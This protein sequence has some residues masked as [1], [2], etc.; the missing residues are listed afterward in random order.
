M[1]LPVRPLSLI[2]ACFLMMVYPSLVWA[3][4]HEPI[5]IHEAR[6]RMGDATGAERPHFDDADWPER[7]LY[8][9][10]D[11]RGIYWIRT[12]IR[13]S[14]DAVHHRPAGVLLSALASAEMFWDG[15][16]IGRKGQVGAAAEDEQPGPLRS[17][18]HIPDSLYTPGEHVLAI[19]LSNHHMPLDFEYSLYGLIVGPL[20]AFERT[21]ID[22][23][24]LLFVGGFLFIVVY[25]GLLFVLDPTRRSL[26]ILALFC[27][28]ISFVIGT[29]SL[30]V[31]YNYTYDWHA[32]RIHAITGLTAAMG[33]L[34]VA[35][36][37]IH[38][39]VPGKKRWLAIVAAITVATITLVA[40]S[41]GAVY[42]MYFVMT[43]AAL[44]ATI[45]AVHAGR[46][47]AKLACGGLALCLV[48]LLSTGTGFSS[49]YFS[50]AFSVF[51][52]GLLGTLAARHHREETRRRKAELRQ[53]QLETELLKRHIQPH[54]LMNTLTAAMEWIEAQPDKGV[55]FLHSVAHLLNRLHAISGSRLIRVEEELRVCQAYVEVM[56][57]RTDTDCRI[58]TTGVN[59]D[60]LIPPAV[61]HTI[62]ENSFTHNSYASGCNIG[63]TLRETVTAGR[64]SYH[65]TS[66]GGTEDIHRQKHARDGTGL[67]Y[68]RARLDDVAPGRWELHSKP[69]TSSSAPNADWCTIIVLP[70]DLAQTEI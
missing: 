55:D 48:A 41:D 65:W 33:L 30:R 18:V 68:I 10:P 42:G 38:F 29:E 67:R 53:S 63:F 46:T 16:R 11:S 36:V 2:T 31:L 27:L 39:D 7:L 47:G 4:S 58:D 34:L 9:A 14:P 17:T 26:G 56:G 5:S 6:V 66:P 3:E 35:F 32:L 20:A 45:W 49:G 51:V 21:P 60:A 23:F 61:F 1:P 59:K 37:V 25:A 22:Y 8:R 13:I 50:P 64:R 52:V 24:P 44:I 70:V 43:C 12:R 54:F 15:V 28:I 19:R 62:V 69:C 57:F 40:S